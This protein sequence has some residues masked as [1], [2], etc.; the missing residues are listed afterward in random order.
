MKE[1]ALT[2][3]FNA[4]SEHSNRSTEQL[5]KCWDNLKNR[6]KRELSQEKKER[7]ATGGGP[8]VPPKDDHPMDDILNNVAIEI[9]DTVD[10]DAIALVDGIMPN[11]DSD[12][13][14]SL[15]KDETDTVP[16]EGGVFLISEI[17]I[18]MEED[19]GIG[20][21]C[22]TR[23]RAVPY[24]TARGTAIERELEARLERNKK[25]AANEQEIHLVRWEEHTLKVEE[26]R[27]KVEEQMIRK[28]IA[29]I[30]LETVLAQM[31]RKKIADIEL[32]TVLA[33]LK[34]IRE[35]C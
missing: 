27:L 8:Y 24:Y 5:K 12:Q 9:A 30:E 11:M 1:H 20:N 15:K 17:H 21:I 4:V 35:N 32:E 25:I 28:K 18:V 14:S 6:R 16:L 31:I 13:P 10:S 23:T 26:Q 34:K 33:K 29:D 22:P 3:E 2:K 19:R 7:M